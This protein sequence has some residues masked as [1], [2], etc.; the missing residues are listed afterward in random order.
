[1]IHPQHRRAVGALFVGLLLVVSLAAPVGLASAQSDDGDSDDS[2]LGD[3]LDVEVS[4]FGDTVDG[5]LGLAAGMID[6]GAASVGGPDRSVVD[7][8]DDLMAEFNQHNATYIG[9]L[10]AK[11]SPSSDRDVLRVR[12]IEDPR[13]PWADSEAASF[14][15]V[16]NVSA[17]TYQS[18]R[19]VETTDRSVDE[20]IV[21]TGI[22]RDQLVDDV[23]AHRETYIEGNGT[24]GKGYERRM[25]SKYAGS[26]SGTIGPL[27]SIPEEYD[28]LEDTD[29]G[30]GS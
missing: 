7:C 24:V 11:T 30:D 1:M 13:R 29:G 2:I 10:N 14:Y 19:A 28:S 3:V 4:G 8:R 5:F 25:T 23:A 21:L 26:V 6:R 16:S 27:P 20:T 12:C 22:A 15:V 17:G 18:A 9:E